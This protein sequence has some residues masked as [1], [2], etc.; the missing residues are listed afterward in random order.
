MFWWL[1]KQYISK[2]IN[3]VKC[4]A[5]RVFT[6]MIPIAGDVRFSTLT[7]YIPLFSEVES[8]GEWIH[9]RENDGTTERTIHLSF[10]KYSELVSNFID[11]F[12]EFSN[13]NPQYKLTNYINILKSHGLDSGLKKCEADI[14]LL[15]TQAILALIMGVIRADRFGE[16]ILLNHLNKAMF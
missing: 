12:Y 5:K 14:S 7:K 4:N 10:V 8:F 6:S 16:G 2:F 3:F 11:D 9:D 1:I 15:N 13:A